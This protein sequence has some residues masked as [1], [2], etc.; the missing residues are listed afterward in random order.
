MSG[1]NA[2]YWEAR[3]NSEMRRGPHN[4]RNSWNAA[5]KLFN[6][7]NKRT[8]CIPLRGSPEYEVVKSL[9]AQIKGGAYLRGTL[10][11]TVIPDGMRFDAYSRLSK[12]PVRLTAKE[13]G[14]LEKE[15]LTV[16]KARMKESAAKTTKQMDEMEADYVRYAK[17]DGQY[18]KMSAGLHAKASAAARP[19]LKKKVVSVAPVIG[20]KKAGEKRRIALISVLDS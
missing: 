1:P 3:R 14:G 7:N 17:E 8:F 18:Y 19:E 5:L 10:D 20:A 12:I 9:Q 6:K 16:L 2:A 13:R 4:H 15:R 11:T